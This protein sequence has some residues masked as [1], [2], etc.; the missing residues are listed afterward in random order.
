MYQV[1]TPEALVILVVHH[2]AKPVSMES[3]VGYG[4]RK[5]V[6]GSKNRS[7]ASTSQ[8]MASERLP[9]RPETVPMVS[10]ARPLTP[11]ANRRT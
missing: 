4:F 2:G 3:L 1:L 5:P 9:T 7:D 10:K 11:Q 8:S 6:N